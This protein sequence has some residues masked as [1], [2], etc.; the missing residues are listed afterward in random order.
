MKDMSEIT[1]EASWTA[2]TNEKE[3]EVWGLEPEGEAEKPGAIGP[4][5]EVK[6]IS[7]NPEGEA[8]TGGK[9]K[10]TPGRGSGGS[11]SEKKS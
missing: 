8:A 7:V 5:S 10:R 4:G 3:K 11:E 2:V 1:S 9:S 6:G